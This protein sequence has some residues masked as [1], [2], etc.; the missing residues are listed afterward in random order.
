MAASELRSSPAC[1]A[2]AAATKHELIIFN[3]II[4]III[5]FIYSANSR[6]A[7]R[8]AARPGM[9]HKKLVKKTLQIPSLSF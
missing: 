9:S 5:Q 4:T 2:T 1:G 6:M 7:D 8:C 3:K